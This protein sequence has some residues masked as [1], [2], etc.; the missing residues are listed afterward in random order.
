MLS[1]T[2]GD[3]KQQETKKQKIPMGLFLL[4]QNSHNHSYNNSEI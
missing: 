1:W 4:L 2:T 3:T